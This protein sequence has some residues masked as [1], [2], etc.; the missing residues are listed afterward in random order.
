[1]LLFRCY[2]S[3]FR[4]RGV[5][6]AVYLFM[7]LSVNKGRYKKSRA[8]VSSFPNENQKMVRQVVRPETLDETLEWSNYVVN[9]ININMFKDCLDEA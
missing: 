2:L 4:K 5:I 1:M 7:Y 8:T 9:T 6:I 3:Y